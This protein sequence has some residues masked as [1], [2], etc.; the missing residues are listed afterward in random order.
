MADD[1]LGEEIKGSAKKIA[2]Q[3]TGDE[4]LEREGEAQREKADAEREAEQREAE[5]AEKRTQARLAEAE[6]RAHERRSED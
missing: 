2:G 4:D 5:A 6:Q 3:A 1:G